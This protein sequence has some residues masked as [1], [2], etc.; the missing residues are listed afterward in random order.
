MNLHCMSLWS[1]YF[2]P[3]TTLLRFFKYTRK[4]FGENEKL[5]GNFL[6]KIN[7]IKVIVK[8]CSNFVFF[9]VGGS[10]ASDG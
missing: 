6:E 10:R 8:T 3:Q 2:I 5:L 7:H 9:P 1:F 4:L